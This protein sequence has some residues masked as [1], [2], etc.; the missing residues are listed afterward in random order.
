[1][2]LKL[3][4]L[5]INN[6]EPATS[7]Q[8]LNPLLFVDQKF[9]PK[10]NKTKSKRR[11]SLWQRW[12]EST[13]HVTL[14]Q[15]RRSACSHEPLLLMCIHS[16]FTLIMLKRLRMSN[17]SRY[18]GVKWDT[19]SSKLYSLMQHFTSTAEHCWRKLFF[20]HKNIK[21]NTDLHFSPPKNKQV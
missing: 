19:D 10:T 18:F 1:M 3:L 13:E 16:F 15:I 2:S 4:L 12:L 5:L 9:P 8:S 20:V 6:R 17:A 14:T 7:Y 21:K 11:S